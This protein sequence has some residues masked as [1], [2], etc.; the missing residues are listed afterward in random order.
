MVE[1]VDVAQTLIEEFLRFWIL[2]RN[3]MVKVSEAGYE[4]D[5]VGL[6][7]GSMIL[8]ANARTQQSTAQYLSQ[9]SHLVDPPQFDS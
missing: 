8:S 9:N 6:R 7:V 1:G 5:R 3:W 4:R 2:G